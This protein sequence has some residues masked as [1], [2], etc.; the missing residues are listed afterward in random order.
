MK[1][2][3]THLENLEEYRRGT[4]AKGITAGIPKHCT[5]YDVG[6][7]PDIGLQWRIGAGFALAIFDIDI[8]YIPRTTKTIEK[9]V[10]DFVRITIPHTS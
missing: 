1:R 9:K 7:F 8:L 10:D 5:L 6:L 4:R 2:V 3:D